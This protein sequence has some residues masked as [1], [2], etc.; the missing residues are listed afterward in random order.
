[1]FK[2]IINFLK[3]SEKKDLK[4]FLGNE[5]YTG[6]FA[7]LKIPTEVYNVLTLPELLGLYESCLHPYFSTLLNQDIKNVVLIG[8][9]NGYYAAGIS[10]FFNPEKLNI[11]ES[12]T[13]WHKKI[14]SWF[15]YNK[16]SNYFI[17]E[18]ADKSSFKEVEK[19]DLLFIDC[20]GYESFLLDP[21]EFEWQKETNIIVEIHPFYIQNIV[22]T[23]SKR[24][25]KTHNIELIYDS[26][27]EDKKIEAI[28]VNLK[29]DINYSKHPNHR[30]I[31]KESK[32]VHTAGIF[33][34]LSPK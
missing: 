23:L 9:N 20:E 3:K 33:M 10:L 30:W 15:I 29:I 28:I 1:M 24:F 21:K 32:K 25:K 34:F 31:I 5:V 11:Y 2:K 8:G 16:F 6:P 18:S 27:E 7:S 17:H 22:N 4:D 12:E 26:F 14:E 19:T 13:K